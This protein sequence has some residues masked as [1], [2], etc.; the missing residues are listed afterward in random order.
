MRKRI[1]QVPFDESLLKALDAISRR[2]QESRSE[3]IRRACR[4]YVESREQDEQDRVYQ[5]GYRRLPEG[6]AIAE[7][8]V[9]LVGEVLP[10]ENW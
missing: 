7:A 9:S 8:Q 6:T 1:I 3:L 4:R 5:E 10:E 2:E